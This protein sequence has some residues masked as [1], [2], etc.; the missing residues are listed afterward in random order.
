MPYHK[1]KRMR[2]TVCS[3]FGRDG[4]G[5]ERFELKVSDGVGHHDLVVI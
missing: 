3:G 1:G 2:R 5:R 4:V